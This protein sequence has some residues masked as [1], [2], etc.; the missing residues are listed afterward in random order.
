MERRGV[1]VE[2]EGTGDWRSETSG[3]ERERKKEKEEGRAR[4]FIVRFWRGESS[5]EVSLEPISSTQESVSTCDMA[6][7][8]LS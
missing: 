6:E 8:Q 3:G 4:A 2:E 7:H 1:L 5:F